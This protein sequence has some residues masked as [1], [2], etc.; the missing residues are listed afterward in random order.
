MCLTPSSPGCGKSAFGMLKYVLTNKFQV[1]YYLCYVTIVLCFFNIYAVV[2]GKC[3]TCL[4]LAY[5][6]SKFKDSRRKTLVNELHAWHKV[7]YSRERMSYYKRSEMAVTSP[8]L[9]WSDI[10]DTV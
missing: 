9:F 6:R 3:Y 1:W 10:V 4:L 2:V 7:M 8:E 5:L